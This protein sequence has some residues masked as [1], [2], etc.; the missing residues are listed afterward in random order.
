VVIHT[1]DQLSASMQV[2]ANNEVWPLV[3]E[4]AYAAFRTW[5]GVSSQNTL[6]SLGWGCAG[7][8]LAALGDPSQSLYLATMSDS[9][10][11]AA[12]QTDLA[13]GQPILFQT[14]T[15]A[16]TMVPSHV[17]VITAVSTDAQGVCWVTTYNPWGFYDART[18]ADL[19]QNSAGALV[20]GAP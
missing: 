1:N 5:D 3:L 2:V 15:T 4:K 16:P 10:I 7:T 18:E 6:A 11:Y 14:S 12:L 19:V 8:A 9:D 13:A 17:Y 20:I